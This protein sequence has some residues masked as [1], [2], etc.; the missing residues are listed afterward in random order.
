MDIPANLRGAAAAVATAIR[1]AWALRWRL[2]AMHAAFVLGGWAVLSPLTGAAVQAAVALSGEPA[3]T[4]Q[5]IA[6]FLLSPLGLAAGV[7][8]AGL[9]LAVAILEVATMM[10]LDLADR[11][12]VR[13]GLLAAVGFALRRLPLLVVF[14]GL[15]IARALAIAAP[16]ALAGWLS[17]RGL[18]A[19]ADINYYLA[20]WPPEAVRAALILAVLGVAAGLVLLNRFAGMAG[21]ITLCFSLPEFFQRRIHRWSRL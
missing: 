5:A 6:R 8:V 12:G 1:R 15:L 9:A 7:L 17:V 3:L 18:L 16:F 2:L 13:F 14:A 21:Q 4:D 20:E 10:A 11:R 19:A